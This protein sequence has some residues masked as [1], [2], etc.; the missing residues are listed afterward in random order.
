MRGSW[1]DGIGDSSD[2]ST[3]EAAG[4]HDVPAAR[5]LTKP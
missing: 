1:L 2:S 5:M 3:S 4:T